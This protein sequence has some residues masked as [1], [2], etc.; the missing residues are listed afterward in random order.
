LLS[1]KIIDIVI[2]PYTGE[3]FFATE[4]G[5]VSYRGNATE[6]TDKYE[7][8]K[9]F[10][11]PVRPDFTGVVSITGLYKDADV[12]ITDITGNL[13]WQG[14]AEGST[15]TWNLYDYNGRKAKTGVYPVFSTATDG[16]QTYVTKI[17]VI[18]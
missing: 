9:V 7:N 3:I 12:K 5:L 6:G 4:K 16:S 1:N 11:N 17:A 10:P 15:A 13:I 8:V 2:Q 18:E 14:K